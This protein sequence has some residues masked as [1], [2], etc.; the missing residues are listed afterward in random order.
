MA[1]AH[2]WVTRGRTQEDVGNLTTIVLLYYCC[3]QALL[4]VASNALMESG[5]HLL[6]QSRAFATRNGQQGV[7]MILTLIQTKHTSSIYWYLP[8]WPLNLCYIPGFYRVFLENALSSCLWV[9]ARKL[10][11]RGLVIPILFS[12]PKHT[13]FS[14]SNWANYQPNS[15]C[16]TLITGLN[17]RVVLH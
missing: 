1:Q 4:Y 13:L 7:H 5:V 15:Y 12:N 8:D 17:C 14:L 9:C 11:N 16:S 6:I 10:S 3:L 2:M